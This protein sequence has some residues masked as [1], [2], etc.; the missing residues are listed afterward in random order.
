M[1]R[2]SP[3]V[4]VLEFNRANNI[5]KRYWFAAVEMQ[6]MSLISHASAIMLARLKLSYR[7]IRDAIWHID[8][9]KLNIDN[10]KSIKQYIPTKEEVNGC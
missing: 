7:E 10:L 3:L 5:G 4:T 9:D 2:K 1:V 8:D 6:T